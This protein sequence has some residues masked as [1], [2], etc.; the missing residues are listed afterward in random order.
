[1]TL[2]PKARE[3]PCRVFSSAAGLTSKHKIHISRVWCLP[4]GGVGGVGGRVGLCEQTCLRPCLRTRGPGR[5]T[6]LLAASP[7]S[8]GLSSAFRADRFLVPITQIR[9][10]GEVTVARSARWELRHKRGGTQ[11]THRKAGSGS[12]QTTCAACLRGQ[13]RGLGPVRR[14]GTA[15]QSSL[16]GKP[17]RTVTRAPMPAG[18][19]G[20]TLTVPPVLA[21]LGRARAVRSASPLGFN[22]RVTFGPPPVFP[23][24]FTFRTTAYPFKP[25][26]FDFLNLKK[27][28]HGHSFPRA[29]RP[30]Q[31]GRSPSSRFSAC[32]RSDSRAAF[33]GLTSS[34]HVKPRPAEGLTLVIES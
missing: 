16:C 23:Q 19:T 22:P 2:L 14:P 18:K 33:E 12:R 29:P 13:A 8:A 20:R 15:V 32:R 1:M 27:P 34:H 7:E 9:V 30:D 10:K 5:E 24:G 3:A 26:G 6:G 4:V 17:G 21:T 28:E 11:Q 25:A 31:R